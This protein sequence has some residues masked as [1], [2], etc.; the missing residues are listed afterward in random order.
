MTDSFLQ[1]RALENGGVQISIETFSKGDS[2]NK[3]IKKSKVRVESMD[4]IE[5]IIKKSLKV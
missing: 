2:I 4:E 1:D 3:Y 5:V